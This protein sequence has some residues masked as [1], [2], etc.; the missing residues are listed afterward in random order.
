M[1]DMGLSRRLGTELWRSREH[2]GQ[3]IQIWEVVETEAMGMD[4]L[5]QEE[6]TGGVEGPRQ[7]PEERRAVGE[8]GLRKHGQRQVENRCGVHIDQGE[9]CKEGVEGMLNTKRLGKIKTEKYALDL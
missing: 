3:M 1:W 6:C 8:R 5:A 4:G 2:S 7:S 9:Y